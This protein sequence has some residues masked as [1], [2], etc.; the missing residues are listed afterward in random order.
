MALHY[1][2]LAEHRLVIALVTRSGYD[3]KSGAW[4]L[5]LAA[6][7][8]A[9]CGWLSGCLGEVARAERYTLTAIR[10]ATAAGARRHVATYMSDLAVSHL[11]AGVPQDALS[12]VHA[13]RAAVRR[14]PPPLRAGL[15]IREARALACLGETAASA[16]APERATHTLASRTDWD[17]TGPLHINVD[18]QWVAINSG[19]AWLHLGRPKKALTYFT[20]LLNDGPPSRTPTPPSPYTAR[21]LLQ[22][23]DTQLALG[24]LDAAA[25]TAHRAVALVGSLPTGLA[26]QY[27]QRFA[28]HSTEPVVRDLIDLLAEQPAHR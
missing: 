17:P 5:L 15:H 28:P 16:Q 2:A 24:E 26:H 25:H 6:R 19:T 3:R 27:R 1:A 22:V 8:A 13:A 21:N 7:T 10:T 20:T 11:V 9:L 12:L 23:T 18:E 14:P 4:L